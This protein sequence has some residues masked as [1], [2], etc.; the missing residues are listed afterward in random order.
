MKKTAPKPA[1]KPDIH[2]RLTAEDYR[3]LQQ[4]AERMD[5]S[6]SYLIEKIIREWIEAAK[7]EPVDTQ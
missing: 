6:M 3:F 7:K 5:R 1:A 4:V 2:F